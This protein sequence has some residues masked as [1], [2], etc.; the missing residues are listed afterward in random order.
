M[1][2]EKVN[3]FC[4]PYRVS[5]WFLGRLKKND[6]E[7]EEFY[8]VRA[9]NEIWVRQRVRY[10]HG[11]NCGDCK[12]S[13]LKTDYDPTMNNHPYKTKQILPEGT[14]IIDVPEEFILEVS[15]SLSEAWLR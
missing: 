11:N 2:K 6:H 12:V 7:L 5:A 15:P 4:K 9:T 14:K 8:Y 10:P 3:L 1:E 13:T